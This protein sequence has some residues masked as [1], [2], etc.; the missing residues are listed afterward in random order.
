MFVWTYLAGETAVNQIPMSVFDRSRGSTRLPSPRPQE[1]RVK[2]T[3]APPPFRGT[4]PKTT[5]VLS[6]TCIDSRFCPL[7]RQRPPPVSASTAG[8]FAAPRTGRLLSCKA[9]RD[10]LL[11]LLLLLLLSL[12]LVV[13]VVVVFLSCKAFH[14][15]TSQGTPNLPT[16]S[17]P[18][19]IRWLKVPGNP[20]WTWEFH[21]L[22][23]RLCLSQTLWNPES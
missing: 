15:V 4:S 8:R 19:K 7:A 16:K 20:L 2:R 21:P 10:V 22:K 23:S 6:P 3:P 14:S 11:S 5:P 17:I 18:T 13:V 12:V 9:P 1:T